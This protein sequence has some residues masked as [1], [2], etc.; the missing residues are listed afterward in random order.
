MII[1]SFHH[2]PLLVQ[3]S[4]PSRQLS[5]VKKLACELWAST[6][7]ARRY[8]QRH[9][10]FFI[11][12][13]S[14][15]QKAQF[16]KMDDLWAAAH[17]LL[18]RR[19]L[20]EPVDV[21]F[22]E[23]PA[24]HRGTIPANT[25]RQPQISPQYPTNTVDQHAISACDTDNWRIAEQGSG[26]TKASEEQPCIMITLIE[27]TPRRISQMTHC[28]RLSATVVNLVLVLYVRR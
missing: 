12:I 9:R 10:V 22:L 24:F 26:D 27:Q 13:F 19:S 21:D 15:A 18:I 1:F 8:D 4:P 2:Q 28:V 14:S 25:C 3:T 7:T 17:T 20:R 6:G 23:F 11:A 5:K 16:D